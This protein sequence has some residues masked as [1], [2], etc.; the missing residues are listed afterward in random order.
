[1]SLVGQ[2]TDI[3]LQA[4]Q[5]IVFHLI[6]EQAFQLDL[7]GGLILFF[8][9]GSMAPDDTRPRQVKNDLVFNHFDSAIV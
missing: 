9:A 3:V 2:Q 5:A 8:V 1:M 4:L 6:I 7:R